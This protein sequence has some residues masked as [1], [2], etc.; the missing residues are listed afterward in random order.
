MLDEKFKNDFY[1]D[2][3]KILCDVNKECISINDKCIDGSKLENKNLKEDVDKIL[4][5]FQAKYNLSIEELKGKINENYENAKKYL[6]N[7]IK[8]KNEKDEYVNNILLNNYLEIDDNIKVSPHQKLVDKILSI[9]DFIE[10][11][12]LIKKFCIKYTRDAVY[13]E[14]LY[15]LYCN[16]TSI[17]LIPKF[18]LKLA[19]AF[20]N[21]QDYNKELD[22]ICANQGTISDDNNYWVDKY[23][24]YIIKQIDFSSDEGYDEQGYKLN[25]KEILDNEY[26]INLNKNN[27]SINPDVIIIRNILKTMTQMMGINLENKYE[28]I[29]NNVI[30]TLKANMYTKEEYEKIIAKALKKDTKSKGKTPIYEDVYNQLLLLLT[31]SYLIVGIQVNIPSI[32]T[33]KT[34]P[35]C[36]KSFSGYPFDGEQDK[37]TLIYITCIA[38]KIKSS[39]KPWNTLLKITEINIVKKL[40]SIIEKYIIND[41]NVIELINNKKEYLLLNKEEYIPDELSIKNWDNFLPPLYDLKIN[42]NNNQPLS[43]T[44]KNELLEIYNKGKKNNILETLL[45]K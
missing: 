32:K 3:N 41:K 31:L 13:D 37:T 39:I 44:F 5:S 1:I 27:V 20:L 2:S 40:E 36:I 8:I 42:K 7:I 34:F 28:F 15:W 43:D 33:K 22:T 9:K 38:N 30:T 29:I 18:L 45:S 17:K 35:G 4:D 25:T 21:K 14:D 19:N 24:G 23:S 16:E 26:N 10:R 12:N 6:K 11:Q